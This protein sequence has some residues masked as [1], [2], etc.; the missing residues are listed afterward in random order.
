[1]FDTLRNFYLN[2]FFYDK[3]I[4]KSFDGTF[5]YK[6]STHLLSSIVKI[7]T[8]KINIDEFA[9]ETV[10]TNT[11]I[12]QKQ[13]KKLNNFFWIFSLDLKSS[14]SS[15]QQVIKNWIEINQKYNLKSWEFVT[16]AKRIIAWLSNSRLTYDDS[17]EEYKDSFNFI[18]Q[19]Q[20]FHLLN[21]I[22]NLKNYDDKLVGITATILFSLS[23]KNQQKLLT[24]SLDYLKKI[25]KNSLDKYGFP[26]S[27]SIQQSIFYLKY[28]ILI[29]EWFKESQIN[30]PEFIT[31]A[32]SLAK[33]IMTFVFMPNVSL[34][35][36]DSPEI[37][38]RTFFHL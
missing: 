34:P 5:Q 17:T 28:L 9:L 15:V 13:F 20:T 27:R 10:W 30:I 6:P 38:R 7:Q 3:K 11:S 36:K 24:I 22:K 18:M 32:I 33:D 21:Q 14:S 12:N 2:S 16:T 4:S 23:Y 35:I 25:I 8:K 19:K 26:K 29:R 1:M 31:S 37:L